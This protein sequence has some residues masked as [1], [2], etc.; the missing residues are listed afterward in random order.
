MA[1]FANRNNIQAG[2]DIARG[3]A[4]AARFPLSASPTGKPIDLTTS[5]VLLHQCTNFALDEVYLWVSNYHA[6]D[7]NVTMSFD[8]ATT[9]DS[10][11]IIVTVTGQT[12]LSLLYPGVPHV[13]TS[14][15]AKAASN[16]RLNIV[17]FVVRRYRQNPDSD[18]AGYNGSD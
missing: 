16:S 4:G 14:I 7:T 11:S 10:D 2:G 13:A 5:G 12:G 8:N 17:G 6:T 1:G 9:G 18:V 15:H 3:S